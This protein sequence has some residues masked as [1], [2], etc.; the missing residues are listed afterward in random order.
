M[1]PMLT[2]RFEPQ[3]EACALVDAALSTAAVSRCASLPPLALIAMLMFS[4]LLA[5]CGFQLRGVGAAQL[6]A[7]WTPVLIESGGEVGALVAS[8]LT[9]SA[10]AEAAVTNDPAAARLRIRVQSQSRSSE[11]VALDPEGKGIAYDLIYS[12]RFDA[13]DAGGNPIMNPQTIR[14]DRTFD[15]DPNDAVLGKAEEAEIIYQ[16]LVQEAANQLVFRV[17]AYLNAM[18]AKD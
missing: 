15:D 9:R 1:K 16:E 3:T 10:G 17:R 5:G 18:S 7:D 6:P 8:Q 13:V 2:Q 11:V 14:V 4:L 12:V